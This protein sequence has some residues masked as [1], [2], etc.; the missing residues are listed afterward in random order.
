MSTFF[1]SISNVPDSPTEGGSSDTGSIVP[2]L[3]LTPCYQPSA[4]V[5]M[6]RHDRNYGPSGSNSETIFMNA[7]SVNTRSRTEFLPEARLYRTLSQPVDLRIKENKRKARFS[8]DTK[9]WKASEFSMGETKAAAYE[10]VKHLTPFGISHALRTKYAQF[11]GPF[12][13]FSSS[14][15]NPITASSKEEN[16]LLF[17]TRSSRIPSRQNSRRDSFVIPD[18]ARD[19]Y[20][21]QNAEPITK[22][23]PASRYFD[24]LEGPELEI[25]KESE[26]DILL[27]VDKT[28][29]FLLRFPI[30]T[31]GICLGLGS[32]AMLWKA[33]YTTASLP[34]LHIPPQINI[35]VWCLALLSL[36]VIFSVYCL[37][38]LF[39]FE[40]VR[41][42]YYHPVRANFFFAP[43]IACMFLSI[44]VPPAIANTIHPYLFCIFMTPIFLLELKIYGQWL[45]G[46][47]RRLSKVANPCSH[48]SVVGNFVGAR[49]AALVGLKEAAIFLLAVG[50][51]HYLVL[52]VTLYQRLPT[53]E[54][55]PRELHPVFFL[56]IAA[57]CTASVAWQMITGEFDS[58]SRI[59]YFIGL[60]LFTSLIVRIN[61]FRGLRFSVAWWAYS[62][63]T[64]SLSIAT[65]KYS[66]TVTNP[67]TRTLSIV[68]S[69][70]S[71]LAVSLLLI[72]TI[73]H[74]FYWGSLFPNDMA[75]AITHA[76]Q[77]TTQN[78]KPTCTSPTLKTLN[79][80][81][82]E[83][84]PLDA[85]N[86]NSCHV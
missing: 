63:P 10:R 44:G 82:V 76:T 41:R 35:G 68:L 14:K 71:T 36:V 74:A 11:R 51:G 28:W 22:Q 67:F 15:V 30:S 49:L 62:F 69:I 78:C 72:T 6:E 38:C 52:F 86:E 65:L 20:P 43:W 37:K 75:I 39:Y 24:A 33:L 73:L 29:P 32:Q 25:L 7:D 80:G 2:E 77:E 21:S 57:P 45:S 70:I 16:F 23:M 61:L 54:S 56:F 34:F 3:L 48:L 79:N 27:P 9:D 58:M 85:L 31:F 42:E 18:E 59:S 66:K 50:L 17:R 8:E 64:A 1:N 83:E 60:F 46:G 5:G 4:S 84:S 47:E 13:E 81:I 55:L 19:P 40:A 12:H 53:N 26:A